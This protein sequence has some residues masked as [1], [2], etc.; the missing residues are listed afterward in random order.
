[1]RTELPNG[2]RKPVGPKRAVQLRIPF[3]DANSRHEAEFVVEPVSNSRVLAADAPL[4]VAVFEAGSRRELVSFG[5]RHRSNRRECLRGETVHRQ[6]A[7]TKIRVETR[8]AIEPGTGELLVQED[9]SNVRVGQDIAAKP[10][11]G[12]VRGRY[13]SVLALLNVQDADRVSALT[14]AQARSSEYRQCLPVVRQ[15]NPAREEK[16]SVLELVRSASPEVS[17]TAEIAIVT[18]RKDALVFKEEIALFRKE[19]IEARQVYLLLV[20]LNLGEI[21]V[22]GEVP[23]QPVGHAV[24]HVHATLG[25]AGHRTCR[26]AAAAREHVRLDPQI[27]ARVETSHPFEGPGE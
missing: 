5:I 11:G 21:G 6:V 15:A 17:A 8:E 7:E 14:P 16:A 25:I 19:E 18:E 1:V 3:V 2:A 26:D 12:E 27:L 22:G 23:Y 9:G 20:G 13:A 10:Q 24:L 4:P